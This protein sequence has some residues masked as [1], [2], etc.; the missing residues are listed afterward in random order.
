MI[1]APD[2]SAIQGIKHA[3]FTRSGGAS[4]GIYQSLNIGLGS[5][6]HRDSVL[7][8][9]SRVCRNLSVSEDALA[10][11][12]QVH[13]A[14]AVKVSK[15]W[16][17]GKG[18][19]AD[20]VVTDKAGIALGIATA[21]CGPVLFADKSANVIGAAHSGWRGAH[22]GILEATVIAMEELGSTRRDI[23]AVLGPT[24]S[25]KAYEVGPEFKERFIT[26]QSG[27][28]KYFQPSARQDHAMFDLPAYIVA[29][30]QGIGVGTVADLSLC[31]YAD[32]KRF[33]S[34]R[35]STHLNEP[36][37]GRLM[38]AITLKER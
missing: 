32:D 16:E 26:S 29:R 15:V 3:F 34:Y 14:T 28:E 27:N 38:S 22:D 8:N 2:L 10:T 7:E 9:R 13:S 33:Y 36:D 35:R 18:P 24:I 21:D 6:D 30:L 37:Y 17:P 19:K 12:H 31:T 25:A 23:I 20:A 4:E 5:K 1:E 11:P